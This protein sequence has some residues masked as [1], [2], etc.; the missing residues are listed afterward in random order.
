M[1]VVKIRGKAKALNCAVNIFV[2]VLRRVSHGPV[3]ENIEA[4]FRG[5]CCKKFV[6]SPITTQ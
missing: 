1:E 4:A 6:V 5:N 3:A 2:N